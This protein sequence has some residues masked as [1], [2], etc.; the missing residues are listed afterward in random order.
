L[1]RHS[2]PEEV[3]QT[4]LYLASDESAMMTAH[5]F[6]RVPRDDLRE[7]VAA[8]TYGY[9]HRRARNPRQG[10]DRNRTGVNGFAGD[11]RGC[12]LALLSQ[13]RVAQLL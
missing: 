6:A 5:T 7:A 10:D 1:G 9:P 11:N 4:A 2:A 3:A 13:I 8:I 12:R